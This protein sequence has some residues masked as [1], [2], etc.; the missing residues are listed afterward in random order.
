MR[1]MRSAPNASTQAL[2]RPNALPLTYPRL[3]F[4]TGRGGTIGYGDGG[5]DAHIGFEVV[6]NLGSWPHLTA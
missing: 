5:G 3:T 6:E 2:T 1:W 4:A